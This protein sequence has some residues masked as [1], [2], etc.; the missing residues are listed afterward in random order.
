METLDYLIPITLGFLGH[1]FLQLL[2]RKTLKIPYELH[3]LTSKKRITSK[4]NSY[5]INYTCIF[6]ATTMCL[7]GLTSSLLNPYS[8]T[9]QMQKTDK[10]FLIFSTSYYIFDICY[11]HWAGLLN[12]PLLLHH[13]IMIF[14]NPYSIFTDQHVSILRFV[15]FIGEVSNPLLCLHQNIGL[16]R[17][18]KSVSR[19]FGF[20]FCVLFIFLRVFVCGYF[21]LLWH[22]EPRV[23]YFFIS[24][25][26]VMFFIG[27]VWS[28][29]TV[30]KLR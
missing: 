30:N 24:V 17:G 4:Y 16:Y 15:Y 25:F 5:I 14:I 20:F 10:K 19:G 12:G 6:H 11:E 7:Y 26:G 13:L 9:A 29:Q 22:M 3:K 23:S 1:F 27:F 2:L 8:M 21:H 18:F 28:F